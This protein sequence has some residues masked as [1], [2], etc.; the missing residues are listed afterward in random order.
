LLITALDNPFYR[1]IA[2]QLGADDLIT[3]PVNWQEI[4]QR[5]THLI[6]RTS[7]NQSAA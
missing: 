6:R 4:V 3:K 1:A 2:Q 5:S 7:S